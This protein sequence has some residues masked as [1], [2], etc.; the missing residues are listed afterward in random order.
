[1][2]GLDSKVLSDAC[3]NCAKKY[4]WPPSFKE[5]SEECTIIVH[6]RENKQPIQFKSCDEEVM[7]LERRSREKSDK[8]LREKF[9][10]IWKKPKEKK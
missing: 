3:N 6:A 7:E 10:D 2:K 8:E 9:P 5:F 1:M 4:A